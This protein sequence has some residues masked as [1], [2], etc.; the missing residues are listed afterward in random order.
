MT[1]LILFAITG[2]LLTGCVTAPVEYYYGAYSKTLY[3]SRKYNTEEALDRHKKTLEDIIE[4]SGKKGVRVPPGIYAEYAYLL[5]LGSNPEAE[6]YFSLEVSTYPE[7]ERFVSFILAQL[8]QA[9]ASDEET[10]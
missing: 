1:R 5:A 9:N 10:N 8:K 2:L 7:S 3:H 4:T 6:R